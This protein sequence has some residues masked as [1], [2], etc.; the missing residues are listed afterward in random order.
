M[1]Y[2]YLAYL[3]APAVITACATQPPGADLTTRV[4]VV[5]IGQ[6]K[7]A[8]KDYVLLVKAGRDYPVQM[9]VE[10]SFLTKTGAA[11]TTV[12]VKRDVYLYK[13]W[14]SFDGK[15]WE[16]GKL[17]LTVGVGMDPESG[18]VEIKVSDKVAEK[19]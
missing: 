11:E 9:N 12:R 2:R 5:E 19:K 13:H 15:T 18:K 6:P 4:P 8:E 1:K 10:G 14:T 17:D 3:L 7:P 16:R